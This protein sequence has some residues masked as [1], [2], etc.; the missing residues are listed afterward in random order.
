MV[1]QIYTT[2]LLPVEF[3]PQV[4]SLDISIL[5]KC[6]ILWKIFLPLLTYT[7]EN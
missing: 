1:T 6:N 3:D 4:R 7:G 2:F 5:N